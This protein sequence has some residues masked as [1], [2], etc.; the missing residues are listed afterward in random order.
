MRSGTRRSFIQAAIGSG[1]LGSSLGMLNSANSSESS[2]PKEAP[3]GESEI[4]VHSEANPGNTTSLDEEHCFAAPGFFATHDIEPGQQIRI[5]R[6]DERY[7]VFTV[8]E[9]PRHLNGDNKTVWVSTLGSNRLGEEPPFEAT[10]DPV[11]PQG[12]YDREKARGENEFIERLEDSGDSRLVV[13][14]P[15]GGGI[16]PHTDQQAV[17]VA[18]Q[19]DDVTTWR[20]LGFHR[21]GSFDRWHI[22]S[23][24]IHPQSYPALGS[25]A[26]RGFEYAVSFHGFDGDGILIGGKAPPELKESI[27]SGI[28]RVHPDSTRVEIVNQGKYGGDSPEN[29]V[30]WLTSGGGNGIQIEQGP[31][32]R[33]Q[34]GIETA[35][36]VAD[37]CER[38]MLG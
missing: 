22:T 38:E 25:I 20:G 23:T 27:Q 4:S 14:A 6:S 12:A 13:I 28:A 31:A 26:D 18:D 37:V 8:F 5:R 24:D 17:H 30:N 32:V 35:R 2:E 29:V 9:A 7:A 33:E 34:R 21:E 15:H 36:A 11:V 10:I 1:V 3:Y 16:E 19:L